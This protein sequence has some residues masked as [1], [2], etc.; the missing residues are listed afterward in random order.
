MDLDAPLVGQPGQ[1]CF[2]IAEN[3]I[4]GFIAIG[5]VD[6]QGRYPLRGIGRALFLVKSLPC[7]A[8]R[9]ALQDQGR[10]RR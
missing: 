3:V 6:G 2:V 9:V 10:S 8:V 7:N 5:V 1:G 4:D